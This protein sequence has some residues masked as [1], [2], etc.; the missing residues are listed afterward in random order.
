MKRMTKYTIV[1]LFAIGA[2]LI[3]LISSAAVPMVPASFSKL[4]EQA[5]PGVVN[6]QTVKNIQGG[7]RVFQHFFGSPFGGNQRGLE[8]FL[9]LFYASS[10]E[11]GPKVL[12]GQDLSSIKRGILSPTTM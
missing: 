3:P 8:E 6:I 9:D 2:M 7:G 5:K 10:P 11:T 4:A 1:A 12:W